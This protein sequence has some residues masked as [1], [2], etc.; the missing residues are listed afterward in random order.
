MTKGLIPV[1]TPLTAAVLGDVAAP[2]S[3]IVHGQ[4][5]IRP[6]Q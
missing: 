3:T 1:T 2:P 5:S 6:V 4:S